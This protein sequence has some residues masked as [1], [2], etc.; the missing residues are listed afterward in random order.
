LT[1]SRS[2]AITWER[3]RFASRR[4]GWFQSDDE[5]PRCLVNGNVN[6]PCSSLAC[7]LDWF[8]GPL[9]PFHLTPPLRRARSTYS[10]G[11]DVLVV[12]EAWDYS[13]SPRRKYVARV[14]G[15]KLSN[16]DAQRV[17]QETASGGPFQTNSASCTGSG[18]DLTFYRY[19]PTAAQLH[20]LFTGPSLS[21]VGLSDE[22]TSYKL[23][24]NPV[25]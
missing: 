24:Y 4:R 17:D 10:C 18:F 19:T 22:S 8:L 16:G 6:F 14:N 23:N 12:T 7:S 11:S 5:R 3:S 13:A 9:L 1:A 20:F 25:P 2:L 21:H 15:K